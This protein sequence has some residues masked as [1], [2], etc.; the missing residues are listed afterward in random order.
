MKDANRPIRTAFFNRI[1][2]LGYSCYDTVP[3]TATTPYCYLYN[4]SA[5]Q[6]GNQDSFGQIASI[7]VD[8]VKEYQKDFGGGKDVDA[9]ANAI[10]ES[11]LQMPPNQL[12]VSGFDTISCTLEAS[13]TISSTTTTN[14]IFI[15][16]L[17]FKLNVYQF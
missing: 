16:T 4:Q 5:Y 12:S 17:T 7:S 3:E 10:I 15:R 9:I 13:N 14:T 11:I 8:I 2:G 1:I 6:D